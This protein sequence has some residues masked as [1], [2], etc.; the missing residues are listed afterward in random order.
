MRERERERAWLER[1]IVASA[2]TR[3]VNN[4]DIDR[5]CTD[6]NN[7]RVLIIM[8]VVVRAISLAVE[9]ATVLN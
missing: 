8:S 4:R 7:R 6:T 5:L 9:S 3:S 1:A 2:A